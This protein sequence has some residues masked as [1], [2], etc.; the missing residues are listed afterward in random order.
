LI[1]KQQ[2]IMNKTRL[3]IFSDGILAIVITIMVLEMKAPESK[4]WSAL[5]P[6][7]PVLLS[8]VLSFIYLSIYWLNHHL[9]FQA[10]ERVNTQVIWANMNL[11]FWLS[12]IP[13]TTSWMGENHLDAVPVAIYGLILLM[14]AIAF[15]LLEVVLVRLHKEK[16]KLA[17]TISQGNKERISIALYITGMA[18]AFVHVGISIACYVIV[19]LMWI[20][21]SHK[22]EQ[23]ITDKR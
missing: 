7:I 11:L 8:Y 22:L 14:S 19:A 1:I 2:G 10:I 20:I 13:F 4:E 17:R 15:R 18:L 6:V 9:L 23:V 12:L 21:P 16:E 5:V 3:E